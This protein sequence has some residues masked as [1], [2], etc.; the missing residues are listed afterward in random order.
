VGADDERRGV[1][2]VGVAERAR[3]E[4]VGEDEGGGGDGGERAEVAR[5][6][7]AEGVEGA[8]G[9][10]GRGQGQER[11]DGQGGERVGE[12]LE[13]QSAISILIVGDGIASTASCRDRRGRPQGGRRTVRT[14]SDTVPTNLS[15][16]TLLAAMV[17][18][19][20]RQDR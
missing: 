10:A 18:I 4:G 14:P 3:G 9:G 13:N 8:G 5:R 2:Q 12:T 6:G 15:T 20:C 16:E 19:V 1:E 7:R 17:A 11:G